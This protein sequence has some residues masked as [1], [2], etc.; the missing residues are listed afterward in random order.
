[1][2]RKGPLERS[3]ACQIDTAIWLRALSSSGPF[4]L[5][6]DLSRSESGPSSAYGRFDPCPTN[7]FTS[8]S[9]RA[10][11]GLQ[12]QSQQVRLLPLV[13]FPV[14]LAAGHR[15]L[16]SAT[17]VRILDG[18]PAFE[19]RPAHEPPSRP[20]LVIQYRPSIL[21]DDELRHPSTEGGALWS[22]TGLEDRAIRK[23]R[24]SNPPPSATFRSV[25]RQGAGSA[26]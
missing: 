8:A 15:L 22:A 5:H 16:A 9:A 3:G 13:P 11:L 2:G 17:E 26:C 6:L 14:R 18:E 25:I 23:V 24:G 1:M 7:H 4:R 20:H 12:N 19:Y 10:R 21:T